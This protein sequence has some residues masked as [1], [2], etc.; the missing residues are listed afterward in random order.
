MSFEDAFTHFQV[1]ETERLRLRQLQPDDAA[2]LYGYY[3]DPEVFKYLDWCGPTSVE[4]AREVIATWNRWY[5][6]KRIIRWGIELKPTHR[7]IGTIFFGDFVGQSRADLGYEL[8]RAS[9][10]QGIMTEALQAVI[11][12]GF[13][14]LEL[15]RIQAMVNPDNPASSRVLKKVGF[16]EEGRLRAYEYHYVRKDFNDVIMLSLLRQEYGQ[17]V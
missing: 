6:E 8:A 7:L 9:W 14:V 5:A 15:H 4:H 3:A 12:F 17:E 11:P 2:D 13:E 1:L 16:M 10:N